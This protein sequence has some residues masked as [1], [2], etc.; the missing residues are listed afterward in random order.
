MTRLRRWDRA[1]ATWRFWLLARPLIGG[2]VGMAIV[3]AFL[4]LRGGESTEPVDALTGTQR[5]GWNRPE[6]VHVLITV[7][8]ATAVGML[9]GLAAEYLHRWWRALAVVAVGGVLLIVRE[10]ADVGGA[11]GE[12]LLALVFLCVFLLAVVVAYDI[13]T[14]RRRGGY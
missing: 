11:G 13:V 3:V 6:D 8:G 5:G 2:A 10:G 14:L 1:A 9:A 4:A 12:A 7:S